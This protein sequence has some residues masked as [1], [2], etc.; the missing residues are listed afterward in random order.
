MSKLLLIGY[1][2]AHLMFPAT[3]YIY[4][5]VFMYAFLNLSSLLHPFPTLK[6]FI[7]HVAFLLFSEN[8]RLLLHTVIIS[9]SIVFITSILSHSMLNSFNYRVIIPKMVKLIF[10]LIT[11][12]LYQIHT[13]II[14]KFWLTKQYVQDGIMQLYISFLLHEFSSKHCQ[15]KGLEMNNTLV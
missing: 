12:N 6:N 1:V 5:S 10:C 9:I 14:P 2:F 3:L 8:T 13:L 11:S 4:N 7:L 15:L